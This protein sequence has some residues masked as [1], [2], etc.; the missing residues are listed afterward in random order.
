[1]WS[2]KMWIHCNKYLGP[3]R[4]AT[5][6]LIISYVFVHIAN[7]SETRV[8]KRNTKSPT[9]FERW[10]E[11]FESVQT[12]CIS[13]KNTQLILEFSFA[14]PG[15]S[16]AIERVFSITNS[17]WTEEKSRFLVETIKAVIKHI[18]RKFCATT[19]ILRFQ[20]NPNYFKKF[21]HLWSIWH[22]PKRKEQLLQH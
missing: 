13:L 15:T 2:N 7:I 10:S 12:E 8:D 18:L 17:L 4:H 9:N 3:F 22:L 5:D 6:F 21:V 1:V 14:I 16:A 19:S 20:T 11:I